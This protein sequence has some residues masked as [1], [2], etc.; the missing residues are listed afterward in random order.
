LVDLDYLTQ[1]E[2]RWVEWAKEYVASGEFAKRLWFVERWL[3][4][5]EAVFR[6]G[7]PRFHSWRHPASP[8]EAPRFD[9]ESFVRRKG[10]M[11]S[12]K[13][14]QATVIARHYQRVLGLSHVLPTAWDRIL[15]E[16]P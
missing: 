1:H 15:Q 2:P 8:Q 14:K 4:C 9:V 6:F 5:D 13:E 11:A 10:R 16:F 7:V 12:L 3:S